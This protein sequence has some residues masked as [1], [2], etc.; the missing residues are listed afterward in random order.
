VGG[1]LDVR[2]DH[3]DG[4]R[5]GRWSVIGS[6]F[7][8]EANFGGAGRCPLKPTSIELGLRS[9]LTWV[10]ACLGEGT[11]AAC[12]PGFGGD[13]ETLRA[14]SCSVDQPS[15][16][17]NSIDERGASLWTLSIKRPPHISYK[18]PVMPRQ[19]QSS[20]SMEVTQ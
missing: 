16:F 14:V 11:E 5:R 2:F 15:P 4:A 7:Y 6:T 20:S 17:S 1:R 10:D 8:F 12:W 19:P 3:T 13:E 9:C 18:L